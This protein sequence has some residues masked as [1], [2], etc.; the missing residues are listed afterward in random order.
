MP[1]PV[2]VP[3]PGSGRSARLTAA[4]RVGLTRALVVGVAPPLTSGN[5]RPATNTARPVLEHGRDAEGVEQGDLVVHAGRA[6]AP[7]LL[8]LGEWRLAGALL[9][10]VLHRDK[11]PDSVAALLPLLRRIAEATKGGE[12]ELPAAGWLA[13]AL[14]FVDPDL[15]LTS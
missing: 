2:P 6:A 3:V 14:R 4:R 11:S 8:R 7:Y 10:R 1:V 9:E 13:Q 15:G 5:T 12:N